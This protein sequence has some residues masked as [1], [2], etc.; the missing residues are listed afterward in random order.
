[1]SD[2]PTQILTIAELAEWLKVSKRSVYNMTRKRGQVR[3]APDNLPILNV[4]GNIRF[5]RCDVEAWL[6]RLAN[7]NAGGRR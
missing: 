2:A 1:M 5:R 4:N 3:M 6:E 7:R